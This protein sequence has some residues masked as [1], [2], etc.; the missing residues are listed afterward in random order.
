MGLVDSLKASIFAPL[1]DDE[2]V[3]PADISHQ[4]C[5][6]L[7]AGV[8]VEEVPRT[9]VILLIDG[10]SKSP[11]EGRPPESGLPWH[12]RLCGR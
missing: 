8:G 10:I 1:H 5:E 4:C 6:F 2:D 3:R 9:G 7:V 11:A 12:R